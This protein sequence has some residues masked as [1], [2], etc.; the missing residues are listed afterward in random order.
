MADDKIELRSEKIRNIIDEPPSK[1]ICY[2]ITI[3][4]I[5]ILVFLIIV[6]FIIRKTPYFNI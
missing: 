3:I 1:I 5:V 6:Y 2:R 4:S